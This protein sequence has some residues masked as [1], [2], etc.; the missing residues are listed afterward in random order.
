MTNFLRLLSP[1]PM[2]GG[3][4]IGDLALRFLRLEDGKIKQASV[5]LPPGVIVEGKV[6]EREKLVAA[7]RKLHQQI[8]HSKKI[9][10]SVL[11]M[12]ASNVY[13][14]SFSM[15]M[16]AEKNLQETAKLNM[17]M[18]SPIDS[19]QAYSGYQIIGETKPGQLEALG[20]FVSIKEVD[21]LRSALQE[22]NFDVIA[23]EFIGMSLTRLVK[24]YSAGLKP[25]VPYL[26]IHLSGDGPD[27]MIVKNGHLYFNYFHSWSAIQSEIGG[28]KM[29]SADVLEFLSTH[30]RQVLNFYTSRWGGAIN[31]IQVIANPISADILE[32]AKKNFGIDAKIL[33]IG[34]YNQITPLWYATLGAALRGM[35]PRS[36]DKDL[37][38]TDTGVDVGY[39]REALFNFIRGWRGVI[40]VVLGFLLIVFGV[41]DIFL[42]RTSTSLAEDLNNRSLVPLSEI[43]ALQTEVQAFNRNVDYALKAQAASDSWAP[44]F[45]KVL[46]H[47]RSLAGQ[48]I[49]IDRF[50][51]DQSLSALMIAKASNDSA[52]INFKNAMLKE[53]NFENVVLP[54]SNIKVNQDGTVSFT[55]QFKIKSLKF[56]AQ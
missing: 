25:D 52:V 14:Q 3:L 6:I 44:I 42:Y 20:A 37:T 46:A 10:H 48:K 17:E 31:D 16:V 49:T 27:L 38:L 35:M 54:L 18:V 26:I 34:K 19:K 29:E 5:Q 1:T 39:Y 21:D 12:P 7:L 45:D 41:A 36:K 30:I 9:T 15:P 53:P 8:D 32:T 23:V 24:N 56:E 51:I 55:L 4:E 13:T 11:V 40:S 28:R 43:Q 22:A 50:Y 47:I 2:I 33:T